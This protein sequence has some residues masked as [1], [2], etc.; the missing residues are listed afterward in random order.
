M[1]HRNFLVGNDLELISDILLDPESSSFLILYEK[2][3]PVVYTAIGAFHFRYYE[4]DDLK[5]EAMLI[6]YQ[7]VL[8]FNPAH[9]NTFGSFYKAN[10]TNYFMTLLRNQAAKKRQVD[11]FSNSL[12]SLIAENGTAYLGPDHSEIAADVQLQIKERLAKLP[13][14]LSGLEW[15][16]LE[17]FCNSNPVSRR[18]IA[19]RLGMS[20]TR[21]YNAANRCKKKLRRL[22]YESCPEVGDDEE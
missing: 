1:S 9:H 12:D 13:L 2:Y 11:Y 17:S 22:L 5:I 19:R 10:L 16:V 21:F 7:S 18:I 15:Q 4:L 20:Y 14:M 6:C 3:C 8:D